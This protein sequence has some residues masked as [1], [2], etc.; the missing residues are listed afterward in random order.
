M[1]EREVAV[2]CRVWDRRKE[3]EEMGW[4][5]VAEKVVVLGGGA[6]TGPYGC[7]SD[8]VGQFFPWAEILHLSIYLPHS[9]P[10]SSPF[11]PLKKKKKEQ[12]KEKKKTSLAF[13]KSVL[14]WDCAWN[15]HSQHLAL[16]WLHNGASKSRTFFYF[17]PTLNWWLSSSI[18]SFLIERTELLRWIYGLARA[19]WL[20]EKLWDTVSQLQLHWSVSWQ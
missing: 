6:D 15:L 20:E 8:E 3:V 14:M 4:R 7:H 13:Y 2:E 11:S 19:H 16:C 18:F 12:K 1:T 5:Q 17:F 9:S 10:F